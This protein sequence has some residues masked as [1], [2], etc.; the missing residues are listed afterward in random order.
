MGN[1][2]THASAHVLGALVCAALG[3]M[4]ARMVTG[5]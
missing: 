1:G 2:L 3:V 5:A 4:L